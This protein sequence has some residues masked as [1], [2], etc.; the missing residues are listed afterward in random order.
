M[1]KYRVYGNTVVSVFKEVWANSE[2]EAID[3]ANEELHYLTEYC[4][5]GGYDKLV[6]VDGSDESVAADDT[7]EWDD[8][9]ELEDDPG[10]RECPRCHEELDEYEGDNGEKFWKCESCGTCYDEDYNEVDP[11]DYFDEDEDEE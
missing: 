1:K 8:V 7:I 5:N 3:R 6:G 4:G 2:D 11:D 10:Y 9:E